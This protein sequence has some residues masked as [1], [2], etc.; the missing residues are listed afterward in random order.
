MERHKFCFVFRSNCV[1]RV[2]NK[3][4]KHYQRPS[5]LPDD[6][7]SSALDWIFMG[8]SGTGAMMHVSNTVKRNCE[9]KCFEL[10]L[11]FIRKIPR[12]YPYS[13]P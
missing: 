1:E 4:R 8:G 9:L 13:I 11:V 5:F 2:Q 6:S 3:L 10:Y 12:I 7:E